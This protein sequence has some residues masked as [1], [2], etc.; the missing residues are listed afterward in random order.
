MT[1][2]DWQEVIDINLSG[3]FNY[4]KHIIK[5]MIRNKYG[6]IINISSIIGL[7]GNTGQINYAASKA[8]LKGNK[9]II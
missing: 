7:N 9:I 2:N 5:N 8:G 3:Y 1:E 4:C 6:R